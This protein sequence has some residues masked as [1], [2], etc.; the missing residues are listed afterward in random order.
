MAVL[1]LA[2]RLVVAAAGLVAQTES[3]VPFQLAV[4]LTA[5]RWLSSTLQTVVDA[6]F[7]AVLGLFLL[8]VLRR[9]LG[10][11]RS[12]VAV[13]IVLLGSFGVGAGAHPAVS[14]ATV[15]LGVAA[16]GAGV[17]VRGGLLAYAVALAVRG[18]LVYSPI[19]LGLDSWYARSGLFALAVV[20]VVGV[21][22]WWLA[23]P[24]TM[25]S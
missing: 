25:R 5:T 3:L 19:T 23:R 18:L 13:W 2:D 7:W 4:G 10:R 17:L 1:T 9:L 14:W 11:P 6:A 24:R 21:A 12:A 8:A 22:G 20:A 16:V 15:G